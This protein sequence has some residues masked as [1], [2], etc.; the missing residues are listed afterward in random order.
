MAIN[1]IAESVEPITKSHARTIAEVNTDGNR[2]G[3]EGRTHGARGGRSHHG[4]RAGRSSHNQ[5]NPHHGGHGC[6]GE[7]GRGFS[8]HGGHF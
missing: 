4:G 7:R 1:F 2:N 3:Q 6:G 5:Y 8:R